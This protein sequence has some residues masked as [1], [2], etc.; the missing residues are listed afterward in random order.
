MRH[1]AAQIFL[2]GNDPE[3]LA[4]LSELLRVDD[5]AIRL[6]SSGSRSPRT[7]VFRVQIATNEARN[8]LPSF[9]GQRSRTVHT[10]GA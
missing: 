2:V 9:R 10:Q 8:T 6:A 7:L 5:I 3:L 4:V 1:A